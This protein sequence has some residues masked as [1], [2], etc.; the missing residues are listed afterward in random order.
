MIMDSDK[1][2]RQII[3]FKKFSWLWVKNN[4]NEVKS[5]TLKYLNIVWMDHKQ[6]W[7]GLL[8]GIYMYWNLF[9]KKKPLQKKKLLFEA[10]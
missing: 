10:V 3:P 5:S 8:Q 7:S 9:K 6:I 2:G 1:K 4:G